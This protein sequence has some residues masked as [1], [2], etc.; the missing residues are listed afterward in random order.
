L[1]ARTETALALVVVVAASCGAPPLPPRL[2]GLPR[3]RVISG[4]EAVRLVAQLH[5]QRY[6]PPDA[7][8][9]EYGRRRELKVWLARY[10]DFPSAY[11]DLERMVRALRLHPTPFLAPRQDRRE[12]NRWFTVGNGAHHLFWVSGTALYWLEGEPESVW[13]AAQELPPPSPAR[14][15]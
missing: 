15:L 10:P 6:T 9:A 3:G 4:R 14:F 12:A 1:R 8:V 11:H 5:G 13:A 2:A 7:L